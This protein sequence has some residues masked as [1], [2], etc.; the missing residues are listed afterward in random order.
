[1][2]NIFYYIDLQ[3]VSLKMNSIYIFFNA[4]Y[5]CVIEMQMS[6]LI[7]FSFVAGECRV[8][9]ETVYNKGWWKIN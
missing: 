7:T 5:E 2:H 8:C 4:S 3:K 9:Y 1:L 6:A